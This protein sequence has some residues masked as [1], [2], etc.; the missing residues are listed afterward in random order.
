MVA[1]VGML[2]SHPYR[3]AKTMPH[4]PHSYSLRNEWDSDE[5][6]YA[7]QAIRDL[8][9]PVRFGNST[10]LQFYAN[11]FF[12]WTM[13]APVRETTVLNR[14]AFPESGTVH[15]Y[16]EVAAEYDGI[17]ETS[18]HEA[19]NS[20]VAQLITTEIGKKGYKKIVD[21]GCGT[22]F[23]L[24]VLKEDVS[25]R[26]LGCDP[27]KGMIDVAREKHPDS[28]LIC[29]RA[30]DLWIDMADTLVV[31]VFGSPSHVEP[32]AFDRFKSMG[33]DL[34]LMYLSPEYQPMTETDCPRFHAPGGDWEN[35]FGKYD[36]YRG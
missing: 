17:Y 8:G 2:E 29:C 18:E 15:P 28:E 25:D 20:D 6:N 35:L 16:D 36:L 4:N 1:M 27:S 22:G 31:S 34:W 9:V 19:E 24:D 13:G 26:Y 5:Y 11:G 10:Y 3:V 21:I 14:K 12:Y 33:A 30:E 23:L 32:T 7:V